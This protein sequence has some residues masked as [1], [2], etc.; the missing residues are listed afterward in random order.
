MAIPAS[1]VFNHKILRAEPTFPLGSLETFDIAGIAHYS[2]DMS[3][4]GDERV[5][6]GLLAECYTPVLWDTL[7]DAGKCTVIQKA[8]GQHPTD[9]WISAISHH[10]LAYAKHRIAHYD[11]EL[12]TFLLVYHPGD[13]VYNWKYFD[14]VKPRAIKDKMFDG[15]RFCSAFAPWFVLVL[16]WVGLALTYP[17]STRET[18]CLKN[19]AFCLATSGLGYMMAY[20]FIGVASEY[21]YYYWPMIAIFVAAVIYISEQREKGLPLSGA[22]RISIAV[23][24]LALV[25]IQITQTKDRD[26]LFS[27]GS[28]ID[29]RTRQHIS[30]P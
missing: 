23:L 3:V 1:D 20:I 25:V 19:A 2:G 12:S 4:F 22:I 9:K 15:I 6:Q 16:G 18:S 30:L 14:H 28:N 29:E 10:P 26:A 17:S 21:R 24:S 7:G 27:G 8:L 5:T 13:K 11:Y